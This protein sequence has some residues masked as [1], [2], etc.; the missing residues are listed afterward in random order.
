MR[1]TF[2]GRKQAS[3]RTALPLSA[4]LSLTHLLYHIMGQMSIV[5]GKFIC[6][7]IMN[8]R[9]KKLTNYLQLHKSSRHGPWR[10]GEGRVEDY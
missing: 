6:K 8:F 3:S 2:R 1:R 7:Q 10:D 4:S 9:A 5:L